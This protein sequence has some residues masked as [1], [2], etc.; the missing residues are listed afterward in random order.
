MTRT[1]GTLGPMGSS[2]RLA[3]ITA[4]MLVVLSAWFVAND[5]FTT[6]PAVIVF[7]IAAVQLYRAK[8]WGGF[9]PA[10]LLAT[11]ALALAFSGL[12]SKDREVLTLAAIS[13]GLALVFFRAGRTLQEYRP[14]NAG[15]LGWILT[16]VALAIMPSVAVAAFNTY[17]VPTGSMEDTFKVGDRVLLLRSS[18]I[19]RGDLIVFRD[20]QDKTQ[21]LVR[22]VIGV[23][24]DRIQLVNKQL[25][26]NGQLVEEPYA[27]NRTN[28]ID[29]FR[30]NFPHEPGIHVHPGLIQML[31]QNVIK[32]EVVVPANSYFV[33][34]DNRD[35]SIDS[36]FWGLVPQKWILGKPVLVYDSESSGRTFRRV[37]GYPLGK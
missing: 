2:V 13:V 24:G 6:A 15:R 21:R 8:P 37:G 19:K 20:P 36:R 7:G 23:R 22:R 28:Y 32:G 27:V 31:V 3:S 9:G 26:L 14:S 5:T 17:R 35:L 25:V 34:G 29:R 30:D 12:R 10:L 4:M 16:T 18:V 1:H 33:L 11:A